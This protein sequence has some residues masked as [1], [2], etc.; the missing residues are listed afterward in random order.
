MVAA[1]VGGDERETCGGDRQVRTIAISRL[2][3]E[4]RFEPCLLISVHRHFDIVRVRGERLEVTRNR[5]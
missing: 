3:Q 2:N 4:L 1:D 5:S